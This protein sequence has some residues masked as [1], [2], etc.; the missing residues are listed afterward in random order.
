MPAPPDP[1]A[2]LD[3][4][5]PAPRDPQSPAERR[6][7]LDDGRVVLFDNG[8]LA[9]GG[10]LGELFEI[11]GSGLRARVPNLTLERRTEDLLQFDAPRIATLVSDLAAS[12]V[13]GVVLA[14]CDWGVSQATALTAAGLERA[15]VPCSIIATEE[16]HRQVLATV[17]RLVPRLSVVRIDYDELSS[18][19]SLATQIRCSVDRI[20]A[21][22]VR[23]DSG[24]QIDQSADA[25]V[26]GWR[27][28]SGV[29]SLPAIG[30]S[31]AFTELMAQSHLGD[32][33]PLV[34]PTARLVEAFC[35]SARVAPEDAMWP[36]LPPR[37]TPV[38]AGD[39]AVVAV[40]AG[41]RARWAPVVFTAFRAMAAP[42]F[43]LFQAAVTTYPGGTLV[44]V[45]GPDAHS[46]GFESGAGALGPGFIAN[47]T[48][49]R[50]VALSYSFLLGAVPRGASFCHQGSPAQFGYCFAENLA[51]SPWEG[52]H[53]DLGFADRTTVTV[54]KCEGPHN[55]VDQRSQSAAQL[56]ETF[57]SC[58]TVLG[59]NSSYVPHAQMILA[60]NPLHARKLSAWG[61]SKE[62]V[63]EYLFDVAQNDA[64]SLDGRG[65]PPIRPESLALAD[66]QPV[67]PDPDDF[68]I[69][70]AG[71]PG[72]ASQ[73][74]LP[75]GFG[76]AITAA[77]S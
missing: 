9:H 6:E 46:F 43:R 38:L 60:L 4:R 11:V 30:T 10:P 73:V 57:S 66:R 68:L 71:G 72:P 12:R 16:G 17:G 21:G 19:Q 37:S 44:L 24:P 31:Q 54:L 56:L 58:L 70:V 42:E 28:E 35:A 33:F 7:S 50:A 23:S 40:A 39:V 3:P 34:P 8:K 20:M 59:A 1:A 18:A 53:A 13:D 22:L 41:C 69:V 67:V 48:T 26:P 61:W 25:R 63:R 49:G 51:A 75:W 15:G 76:R 45:S 65:I 64:G 52:L 27:T 36:A 47:A 14:L 77:V 5:I 2:I 32:G 29:L 62:R 55:V 74:I